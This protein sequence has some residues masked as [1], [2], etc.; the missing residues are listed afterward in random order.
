MNKERVK[1]ILGIIAS[2]CSIISCIVAV[3]GV[4]Q[5]VNFVIDV[6]PIVIPLVNEVKE[7][8][9]DAKGILNGSKITVKYD[10]VR[11]RDTI[12]LP[13]E[14]EQETT[15]LTQTK[16]K[17]GLTLEEN[18][19]LGNSENHVSKQEKQDIDNQEAD[20]RRRMNNIN[21]QKAK[22]HERDL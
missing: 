15:A 2:I 12:Y 14:K 21:K 17:R 4:F 9:L 7:G 5:V 18:A 11:V 13:M 16:Q 19:R 1:E 20:F 3:Y 8:N 6:R 10:T 22:N